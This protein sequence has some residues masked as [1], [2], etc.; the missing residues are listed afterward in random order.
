M[1]TVIHGCGK[2]PVIKT[3]KIELDNL[4]Q[5][6]GYSKKHI[7]KEK[8][9]EAKEKEKIYE[10]LLMPIKCNKQIKKITIENGVIMSPQHYYS[11]ADE[12][13]SDFGIG[14]YKILYKD[15]LV[16]SKG[17]IL[18]KQGYAVNK[19]F[20]GDTM[21]SFNSLANII[22]KDESKDVR[23][24]INQWPPELRTYHSKYHC[25]ANCWLIPMRHG[26]TSAKLSKY[27]SLDYYLSKVECEFINDTEGYFGKFISWDEFKKTHCISTYNTVKNPLTMYKKKDVDNSISELNRIQEFWKLRAKE[28][29]DD[30]ERADELYKYFEKLGLVE[31]E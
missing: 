6:F 2:S 21:Y 5:D 20:M 22:L 23:T 31:N 1:P 15:I 26:R 30:N 16:D 9:M 4:K 19:E 27:D 17:E 8:R 24:A 14:F 28:I 29:V 10:I 7:V 3:G 25:L 18:D 11:G 12:D 13:M